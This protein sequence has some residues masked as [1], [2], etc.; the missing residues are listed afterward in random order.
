MKKLLLIA[1]A[2]S[3]LLFAS[4]AQS[5]AGVSVGIGVGVPGYYG[6]GYPYPYGY[7]YGYGPS[8]GA[9]VWRGPGWYWR[10][11][12]RVWV[13]HRPYYHRHWR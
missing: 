5:N 9:V 8:Y 2:A 4:T 1:L 12:H 13:A 10:G 6:Y 7:P 11:G 3:G